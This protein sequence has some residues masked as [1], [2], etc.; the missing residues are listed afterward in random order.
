MILTAASSLGSSHGEISS[1]LR[2]APSIGV[3][4]LVCDTVVYPCNAQFPFYC[5]QRPF[6]T[7]SQRFSA[8]KTHLLN[9]ATSS[10][11]PVGESAPGVRIAELEFALMLGGPA[12]AEIWRWRSAQ[13]E[14]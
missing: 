10:R 11:V 3:Y 2:E 6:Q 7:I 5:T 1:V 4:P 14:I 8:R 12:P 9:G 13:T